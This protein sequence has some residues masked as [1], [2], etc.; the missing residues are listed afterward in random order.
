MSNVS[1]QWARLRRDTRGLGAVEFALIV[2]LML[3][4]IFG[5]IQI[6]S[7][8]A[9]DRKVSMVTQTTSDLV[10]RYKE[11][12]EVDLDGI[13]TIANAILTPYD[14]TPLKAKIT[15]VYINPANGNACV[16]WSKATSNEVAYDKGKILTVPSALIV[17]NDDD[18][19]VAGQY[20][21]F[22]E[23]TYRYTPA[24]AWFP[25]MPFLDL[26]DKTYTRPRLSA[27]VLRSPAANVTCTS[28][29][30]TLC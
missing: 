24:V 21:I 28:P 22:S 23:V 6:S 3:A 14:S 25:Q 17:K 10:S 19:I 11:V 1:M 27:C 15:Q 30:P 4:M 18:Q 16:Q 20:L 12:A 26:N 29:G 13:I 9:I 5:V 8:I 2:P 7:G